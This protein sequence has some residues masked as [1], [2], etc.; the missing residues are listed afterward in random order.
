MRREDIPQ[1][2]F[3]EYL[4]QRLWLAG[5]RLLE[6]N[7]AMEKVYSP[8]YV[9]ANLMSLENIPFLIRIRALCPLNAQE[10]AGQTVQANGLTAKTKTELMLSYAI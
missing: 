5:G 4:S 3:Q 9:D 6:H 10:K 1:K 7:G 2:H 8:V